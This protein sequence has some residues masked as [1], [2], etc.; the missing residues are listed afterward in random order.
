MGGRR[1]RYIEEE[2]AELPRLQM[3]TQICPDAGMIDWDEDHDGDEG[4]GYRIWHVICGP[5]GRVITV[6]A[7][8]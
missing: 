7:E 5:D 8:D 6:P 1:K 4:T 3:G 2:L